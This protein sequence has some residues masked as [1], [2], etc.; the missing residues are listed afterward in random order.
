MHVNRSVEKIE[1][2]E[3]CR[4]NEINYLIIMFLSQE[5]YFLTK[6][7]YIMSTVP[8][9]VLNRSKRENFTNTEYTLHRIYASNGSLHKLTISSPLKW[10]T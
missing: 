5:D 2:F 1:F 10:F 8:S 9:L 6:N 7:L 3:Y 4:V